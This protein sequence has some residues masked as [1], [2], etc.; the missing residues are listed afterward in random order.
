MSAIRPVSVTAQSVQAR[1]SGR[2]EN[3]ART[4]RSEQGMAIR[5][6]VMTQRQSQFEAAEKIWQADPARQA[7]IADALG[8][9][10]ITVSLRMPRPRKMTFRLFDFL[11]RYVDQDRTAYRE[12]YVMEGFLDG[13]I[14]YPSLKWPDMMDLFLS[15]RG[16]SRRQLRAKAGEINKS[17]STMGLIEPS[18]RW[19][20]SPYQVSQLGRVA[21]DATHD[22]LII[23]SGS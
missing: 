11:E 23:K 17:L 2:L 16:S 7:K 4:I 20:W 18:G 9:D 21:Y 10:V 6:Q 12:T 13:R 15:Q 8:K 14:T 1:F 19:P 22:R 3:V 5:D